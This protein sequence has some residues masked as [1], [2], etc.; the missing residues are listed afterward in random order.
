MDFRDHIILLEK[1]EY[2]TTTGR[3]SFPVVGFV[4]EPSVCTTIVLTDELVK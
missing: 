3:E 1:I 2:D 4:A